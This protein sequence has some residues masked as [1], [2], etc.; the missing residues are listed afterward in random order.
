MG[1][2]DAFLVESS[3]SLTPHSKRALQSLANLTL[4]IS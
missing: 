4:K 1:D 2:I 3:K